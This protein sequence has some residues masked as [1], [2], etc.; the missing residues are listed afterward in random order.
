MTRGWRR[1]LMRWAPAAGAADARGP[2]A[3]WRAQRVGPELPEWPCSMC[4]QQRMLHATELG[5]ATEGAAERAGPLSRHPDPAACPRAVGFSAHPT[6]LLVRGPSIL[7]DTRF[8]FHETLSPSQLPHPIPRSPKV[9]PS[10]LECTHCSQTTRPRSDLKDTPLPPLL[11]CHRTGHEEPLLSRSQAVHPD[12]S[13]RP[14][15]GLQVKTWRPQE[16]CGRGPDGQSG[17]LQP[18]PQRPLETAGQLRGGRSSVAPEPPFH[19]PNTALRGVVF[20]HPAVSHGFSACG[21]QVLS[22]IHWVLL[23]SLPVAVR[24]PKPLSPL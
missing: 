12:S 16:G 14:D 9:Q 8:F 6:P 3:E 18:D 5:E 1:P 2:R 11:S 13:Q 19:S 23:H 20:P 17:R 4:G 24:V 15:T 7:R 10:S 21:R 22:R